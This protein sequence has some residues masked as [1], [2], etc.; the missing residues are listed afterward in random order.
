[1][2]KY[3]ISAAEIFKNEGR[4]RVLEYLCNCWMIQDIKTGKYY[5]ERYGWIDDVYQATRAFDYERDELQKIALYYVRH[6][7][8]EDYR[9]VYIQGW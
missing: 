7:I 2:A 9:W 8:I 5:S 4:Y 6:G 3:E 1:M